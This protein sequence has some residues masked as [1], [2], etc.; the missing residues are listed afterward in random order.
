MSHF[1]S[2]TFPSVA[3]IGSGYW[4]KNLVRNHYALG[5]LKLICDKNEAI[6]AQFKE[7]YPDVEI[8]LALNDV[9]AHKNIQGVVIA[10]PAETHFDLAREVLLS[11]KHLYVEKPLVLRED[12]AEELIQLAED[13]KLTLMVG[14]LLQY[15]PVFIRLKELAAQGDLGRIN[16]IYSHR[17][18]LGKIRREENILWS[19]APHDISMILSLAG[20]SPESVIATGGNYLHQRIADVT[21]THLNFPSGMRAHIFVSW[22]HPF[23]TQQLVVV[24]DQKMAVFDDIRPWPEKLLLYPHEIRWQNNMPVPAKAEPERIEVSQAEPLRL[25]C[26]HFLQCIGNGHRPVTDGHE[27]LLVLKV[28]NASQQ[29]LDQQ[30]VKVWLQHDLNSPIVKAP[31]HLPKPSKTPTLSEGFIHESAVTDDDVVIGRGSKIWHFSHILAGSRIGS[32]CSIGQNVVIGPDVTV[33]NGCKIQNNVSVYKGVTLEDDVFCGPSMVFTN[34][35]N[36][37][38]HIR[39][40]DEIRKTLVKQGASL[41]ANCTIVCGVT[42]GRYAFVAAGAVVTKDIPDYALVMGNPAR[43]MGWICR[44]GERLTDSLECP[45]CGNAYEFDSEDVLRPR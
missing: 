29:S 15:H 18:N 40:M 42:V 8:C 30:G 10:T 19:F 2:Q 9:L 11:G 7:Q 20:E 25:E 28:L 24:G 6:L 34:V 27:G 37:R 22:L 5:A 44:C 4:G 3:V 33:G 13:Q 14:H 16:Y 31:P 38:A 32:A 12:E 17:L 35:F 45:S 26:E 1:N 41:G 21:T 43:L 23:K 36:P 39:R